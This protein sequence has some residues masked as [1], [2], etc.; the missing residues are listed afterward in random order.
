MLPDKIKIACIGDSPKLTSGFGVVTN[1]L[2]RG[3]HEAG[4]DVTAFGFMDTEPDIDRKLPYNFWPCNPFDE[5]GHRTI[6]L[7]LYKLQPD[8]IFII[9]DPGNLDVFADAISS[10]QGLYGQVG[11]L[12]I[13]KVPIVSYTP[14][15][16][17][18]LSTS[19]GNAFFK[20]QNT[21]G[22][23]VVYTPG[24][25][26]RVQLQFSE[27]EPEVVYH[28]ADHAPFHKYEDEKRNHLRKIT[29]LDDYFVVGSIGVNKRTKGFDTLI[30]TARCLKDMEQD[31]G[32]KFY[33]HT[34][35]NQPT[36]YGY[37]LD[38]LASHYGVDDMI[39]FKP[40]IETEPGG[41]IRGISRTSEENFYEL[42]RPETS[43]KRRKLF[44]R[45][46]F[47][48]R[49]N[50]LDLYA[51][52]SQVEGWG[53]PAFEAMACG[54]PTVS[55]NDMSVREEIY[56]GGAYMLNALPV[57]TWSTWHTGSKLAQV[58]PLVLAETILKFK[59]DE[60]LRDEYSQKGI[61]LTKDYKWDDSRDK[62]VGIIKETLN[63]FLSS[64]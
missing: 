28:G 2:Y 32:I 11:G 7:F 19:F 25:R 21:G 54:V 12:T 26:D 39:L 22:T 10:M 55:I 46:G 50:C 57:R 6:S 23:V 1:E 17:F 44:A 58:D 30:Y 27:I 8:V 63:V 41:N 9:C 33:F 56:T 59:N 31:D 35:P 4:F 34:S 53:L 48:D 13:K 62:M 64:M 61:N 20:V 49:I 29:G 60:Q 45:F 18:P 40:E 52:A 36:M 16:G 47:I 51:D 14:I 43:E 3:F 5:L 37:M 42:D 15:E 38:E 24:S